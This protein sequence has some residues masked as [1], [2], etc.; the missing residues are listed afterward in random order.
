MIGNTRSAP[1]Q[2]GV[3]NCFI[4]REDFVLKTKSDTQLR[5][6]RNS[7]GCS[8]SEEVAQRTARQSQVL[9]AAN[10]TRSAAVGIETKVSNV[11]GGNLIRGNRQCAD[12]CHKVVAR[13]LPVKQVKELG[14]RLDGD[15]LIR[16]EVPADTQVNLGKGHAAKFIEG[17]LSPIHHSPVI[18]NAI[19]VD[20]NSGG[21]R[22]WPG[23]LELR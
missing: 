21:Q 8:G 1:E 22:E 17:C 12:I 23:A 15:V 19:S 4:G 18:G 10:R 5:C 14:K 13:V 2:A 6:K 16:P 7:Y 9:E 11:A 20:I 3:P